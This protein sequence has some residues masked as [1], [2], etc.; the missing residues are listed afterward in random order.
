M[1]TPRELE[2]PTLPSIVDAAGTTV[3]EAILLVRVAARWCGLPLG[4]VIETMRPLPTQK[5][6]GTPPFVAGV[7][8]V[9]GRRTPVVDLRRVFDESLPDEPRRMVTLRTGRPANGELRVVA[10]LVDEV[11]GVHRIHDAMGNG[12]PPLLGDATRGAVQDISR[13]DERLVTTLD[14]AR[15]VPQDA[16]PL[17]EVTA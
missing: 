8:L 3:T 7:A 13:L 5:V 9:R 2:A 6:P 12:L 10:V 14:A 4:H 17:L 16:W 11:A 15:I 1:G